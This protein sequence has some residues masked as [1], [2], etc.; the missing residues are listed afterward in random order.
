MAVEWFLV[1]DGKE[2]GPFTVK[3]IKE[4]ADS[5]SLQPNQRLRRSDKSKTVAAR[6]VAGLFTTSSSGDHVAVKRPPPPRMQP[7]PLPATEPPPL[8]F[9]QPPPLPLQNDASAPSA[10][11]PANEKRL[12]PNVTFLLGIWAGVGFCAAVFTFLAINGRL[13]PLVVWL[14][15]AAKQKQSP[16][17]NSERPAPSVAKTEAKIEA[18]DESASQLPNAPA[19]TPSSEEFE[20]GYAEG[21]KFGGEM[22]QT[23]HIQGQ[24]MTEDDFRG[25]ADDVGQYDN[26]YPSGSGRADDWLF[27]WKQG[28][29]TGFGKNLIAE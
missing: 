16:E 17:A 23:L 13:A 28:A 22:G 7:P 29:R 6:K 25:L 11:T 4:L 8:P 24:H 10:P 20:E 5:G 9:M 12:N 26:P 27:G 19:P 18:S 14:E 1:T 2:L 21:L 15:E 3:Q